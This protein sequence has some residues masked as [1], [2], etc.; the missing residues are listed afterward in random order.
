MDENFT[1][2][3]L[4]PFILLKGD[5]LA[6]TRQY[7]RLCRFRLKTFERAVRLCFHSGH[8]YDVLKQ[9]QKCQILLFDMDVGESRGVPWWSSK[10]GRGLSRS[11]VG[12]I[13]GTSSFTSGCFRRWEGARRR[14]RWFTLRG[15]GHAMLDPRRWQALQW[16]PKSPLSPIPRVGGEGA[17]LCP[18]GLSASGLPGTV[19]LAAFLQSG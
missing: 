10:G 18:R 2:L 8:F 16:C 6:T 17:R 4:F 11:S 3:P 15:A 14:Q 5:K 9:C 1:L 13:S 7:E 12:G 19:H